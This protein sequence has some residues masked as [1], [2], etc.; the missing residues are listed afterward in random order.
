M[1]TLDLGYNQLESIPESIGN[2][3]NLEYLYLF[4]NQLTTLPESICML[5]L[6]W[7]GIDLANYP[8]FASGGN[9]LCKACL[10]PDC[11]ETSAYFNVSMEQN[12]YSFLLDAP[13]QDCCPEMGN[14]NGDTEDCE[15]VWNVLDIVMLANCVLALNCADLPY[16]CAGDMNGDGGYNVLDIVTLANCVLAGSCGG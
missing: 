8:Y 9:Y 15:D 14:I 13:Q 10:I 7:D 4:N 12:Y 11:V 6:D 5:D 1:Q 2:L 3:L 16:S